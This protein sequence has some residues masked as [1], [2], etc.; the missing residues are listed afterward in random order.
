LAIHWPAGQPIGLLT[1]T[2]ANLLADQP[3]YQA[4]G[5]AN[6]WLPSQPANQPAS[7]LL[8]INYTSSSVLEDFHNSVN[9]HLPALAAAVTTHGRVFWKVPHCA[10]W[11]SASARKNIR[12]GCRAAPRLGY[13]RA[14]PRPQASRLTRPQGLIVNLVF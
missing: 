7:V 2:S 13:K 12:E 11:T 8:G 5:P 3:T 9:L 6:S 14:A 4:V 10:I 1:N